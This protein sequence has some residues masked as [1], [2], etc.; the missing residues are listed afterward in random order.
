MAALYADIS[1]RLRELQAKRTSADTSLELEV[2]A[3]RRQLT[4][5]ALAMESSTNLSPTMRAVQPFPIQSDSEAA[6]SRYTACS[7]GLGSDDSYVVKLLVADSLARR[8][9]RIEIAA[10]AGDRTMI[11]LSDPQ[12]GWP[13]MSCSMTRAGTLRLYG[14]E[15]FQA[16][17]IVQTAVPASVIV[18][19]GSGKLL[20]GPV[21]VTNETRKYQMAWSALPR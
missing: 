10:G 7:S 19:T 4:E 6:A 2:D 5:A 8:D 12:M 16:P 17:L 9:G 15:A 14:P 1:A 20:A 3:L 21:V 13:L 11:T 18:M